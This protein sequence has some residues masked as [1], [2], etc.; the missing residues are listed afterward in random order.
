MSQAAQILSPAAHHV[1]E[2]CCIRGTTAEKTAARIFDATGERMSPRTV[3]RRMSEWRAQRRRIAGVKDVGLCLA[4][5]RGEEQALLSIGGRVC[6]DLKEHELRAG[7]VVRAVRSFM[8][9]P[10]PLA[11]SEVVIS[12]HLYQIES[13]LL[14]GKEVL[15]A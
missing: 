3:S 8:G 15:H 13:A 5:I 9:Q 14:R 6:R 7:D 1:L 4:A 11:L 12:C 10:T 2:A